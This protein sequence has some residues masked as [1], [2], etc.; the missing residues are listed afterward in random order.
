[1]SMCTP[2]AHMYNPPHAIYTTVYIINFSPLKNSLKKGLRS[3]YILASVTVPH[4]YVT[5]MFE[6]FTCKI[7]CQTFYFISCKFF[8]PILNYF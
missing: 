5:V 3:L 1:M 4:F 2:H 7:I 8:W 6:T